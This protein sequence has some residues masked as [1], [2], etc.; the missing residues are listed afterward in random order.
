MKIISRD[1]FLALPPGTIYHEYK[2]ASTGPLSLKHGT[3]NPQDWQEEVF[4][5]MPENNGGDELV[6]RLYEME[7]TDKAYPLEVGGIT[8]N[9]MHE[10]TQLFMVYD[11]TDVVTLLKA[12]TQYAPELL[13]SASQVALDPP[14]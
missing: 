7:E 6:D 4:N 2:S 8:R 10:D 13:I 12:L 14:A 3:L 9:G 5:G 11:E 1:Q